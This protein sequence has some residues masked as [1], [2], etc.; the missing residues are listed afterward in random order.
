[1]EL[2]S[3]LLGLVFTFSVFAFKSGAGVYYLLAAKPGKAR[4][5]LQMLGFAVSYGMAL[6]LLKIFDTP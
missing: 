4:R 5:R 6:L 1:M 3:L 2:K